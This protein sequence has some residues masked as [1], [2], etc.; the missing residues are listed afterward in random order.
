M[1]LKMQFGEETRFDVPLRQTIRTEATSCS[2]LRRSLWSRTA[3]FRLHLRQIIAKH[4]SAIQIPIEFQVETGFH[5]G[6][7][8]CGIKISS[9]PPRSEE[10]TSELQSP[11]YLV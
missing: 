11:M 4:R 7:E 1:K 2:G 6:V 8:P 3:T 10:H 9:P 5:L